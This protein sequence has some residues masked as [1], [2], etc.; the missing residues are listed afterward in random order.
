MKYENGE[1][2]I[3]AWE[4]LAFIPKEKLLEFIETFSCHDVVIKHVTDQIIE[5]WTENMCHGGSDYTAKS[6]PISALNCARRRIAKESGELAKEE[7]GALEGSLKYHEE[8]IKK[9]REENWKLRES[10]QK[11]SDMLR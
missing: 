7:I 5:G 8:E 10:N 4:M 1:I 2:K 6:E 9:I 3:D 11:L